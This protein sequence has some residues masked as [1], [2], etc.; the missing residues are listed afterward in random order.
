MT[1]VSTN[2][3]I[4]IGTIN[5]K[6]TIELPR[7]GRLISEF[8]FE[9]GLLLKDELYNHAGIVC[10]IDEEEKQLK[11]I[12]A[13]YLRTWVENHVIPYIQTKNNQGSFQIKTTM[14]ID[15][16]RAV[17]E[18][19]Q[20]IRMLRTVEK[21]NPYQLPYMD[22]DG[23]IVFPQKGYDKKNK[24][25][26]ISEL[27]LEDMDFTS[28][29]KYIADLLCDFPFPEDNGVSKSIA[30]S[31]I[32]TAVAE[33]LLPKGSLKPVFLYSANSEGSG[34]TILADLAASILAIEQEAI[35]NDNTEMHKRLNTLVTSG[36]RGIFFDNVKGHLNY[37]ALEEYTT[38]INTTGRIL[39]MHKTFT[40]PAGATVL[41][42]GNGLTITPDMRRRT[43]CCNLFCRELRP[44]DRTFSKILTAST[45][46]QNI[47]QTV[48]AVFGL[49]K[50][51]EKNGRP[52]STLS[53]SHCPEWCDIIAGIVENAG[54]TSPLRKTI[55]NA[56]DSDLED[57]QKLWRNMEINKDYKFLDLVDICEENGLFEAL[58]NQKNIAGDL[59]AS[60]KSRLG[61]VLKRY[62]GKYATANTIFQSSGTNR[63]CYRLAKTLL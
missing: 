49:I 23:K 22:E 39:G 20:F 1:A 18:S 30:I 40:G 8:A 61:L 34:K 7:N 59:E 54:Y 15:T 2:Q 25:L 19:S 32:I 36:K 35:P 27:K 9:L 26:T 55:D 10:K 50:E 44:E 37:S 31:A 17:L 47:G 33:G 48:S 24:I 12:E 3:Q 63:K 56:V 38:A 62:V 52:K 14:S 21:V 6:P 45:I 11:P 53:N 28:S 16:A 57:I 4:N 46:R 60:A 51:W 42:T 5:N 43:L 41:I 29:K 58:I 13:N